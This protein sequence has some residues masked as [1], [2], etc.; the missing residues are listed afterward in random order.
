MG[1]LDLF[2]R[3]PRDIQTLLTDLAVQRKRIQS[4]DI[5]ASLGRSVLESAVRD[6]QG[7]TYMDSSGPTPLAAILDVH[8]TRTLASAGLRA[9]NRKARAAASTAEAGL[10]SL[11]A[12]DV[13]GTVDRLL[14]IMSGSDRDTRDLR[15]TC[16]YFLIEKI[17]SRAATDVVRAL[18]SPDAAIRYQ[19]AHVLRFIKTD[20]SAS[21]AL[22]PLLNDADADVCDMAAQA[23][24]AGLNRR[25]D[26]ITRRLA[27]IDKEL[28]SERDRITGAARSRNDADMGNILIAAVYEEMGQAPK[29]GTRGLGRVKE[30]EAEKAQ[31]ESE[32]SQFLDAA[33]K[34]TES[35]S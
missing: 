21:A 5:I 25:P 9:L 7:F 33:Q 3:R 27:E 18:D 28:A 1:F 15:E 24:A 26:E 16:G 2:R 8:D 13:S 31:L 19:A 29:A 35:T 14:A 34:K 10:E 11:V 12:V 22:T 6:R 20:D 23:L 30:L 17:G 4:A 32:L